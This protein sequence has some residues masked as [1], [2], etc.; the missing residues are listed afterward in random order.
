ML[1]QR[2]NE[3]IDARQAVRSNAEPPSP[4]SQKEPLVPQP[5]RIFI[6]GLFHETHTFLDGTTKWD[7]FQTVR[8]EE[9]LRLK[10][11]SS[12]MGGV[13]EVA[14]QLGWNVVPALS[15]A[16]YPSAIVQDDMFERYWTEFSAALTRCV[17]S[18]PLD[19]IFL[20]LHGAMTCETIDDV[21]GVLLER[22][23]QQLQAV[24][25]TSSTPIPIF[26]VYDLHANFTPKMARFSHCLVAYRENPH[27][28][29]R[30]SAVRAAH[31]LDRCLRTSE[32]PRTLLAQP[33]IVW[34]P[35]GTGTATDPMKTLLQ[36][37]RQLQV[38]HQNFWEVNVTAG[39]AFADTFDTGVSFGIVTTGSDDEAKSA[40]KYLC[41]QAMQLAPL[42]N[43]V[44]RP[45]DDVL[46]ELPRNEPGLMVVVE[47]SD[48]IGGGAPGDCT[49][50]L[51]AFIQHGFTNT[52]V[53][54]CDPDSVRRLQGQSPGMQIELAIGG[55]GSRLDPG[56][57][58]LTV[59]FVRT[60][61]GHF[62]LRDRQSHL[63]SM[64]GDRF[65]MGDCAI[66][67][68]EGITILLTS[69]KTPPMDLGQWLHVGLDPSQ[70]SFV[71]VKAA[72]AHRRAWDPISKGNVWVSTPG[73]CSSD[74]RQLPYRKLRRPVFPL[75]AIDS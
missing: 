15:A 71:G 24:Q 43:V 12:P 20:V 16:A 56:P 26:G 34:P 40:L 44:E 41:D 63:A 17:A 67:E 8:G 27:A 9:I 42:G 45:V 2:Y 37:A 36:M 52:A 31:L 18:G 51:R 14:E 58:V 33:P 38:E 47:P 32:M 25:R 68:Y 73:P 75:D 19:G 1:P 29:A 62:E 59:T 28:D 53:C 4:T 60:C 11:D 57:V 55:R 69:V 13:L 49:G 21:E 50:L 23:S 7:D 30:E 72:V 65:N 39:F 6:A 66:V 10:G 3:P 70:F 46:A 74:L 5:P 64:V 22:L 54:L 35:T 48:N 61:D